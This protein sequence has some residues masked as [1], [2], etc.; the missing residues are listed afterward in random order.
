MNEILPEV[1]QWVNGAMNGLD[2][3]GKI[4]IG[5]L[6]VIVIVCV[7]WW[8]HKTS[9]LIHGFLKSA[10]QVLGCADQK[11]LRLLPLVNRSE[12]KGVYKGR[13]VEVGVVFSGFKSEFLPLPHIQVRLKET[14]GYNINRLPQYA[15]IEKNQLIYKLR[16]NLLWG[17]FDRN[18]IHVFSKNYLVIALEK[19]L[20]TAE[21]LERGREVKEFFK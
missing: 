14:L 2:G 17:V 4:L 9:V 7:F 16:L 3:F 5:T 8:L 19:L 15:F 21:D 18:Y 6:F 11:R 13:D 1:D 20:A 10:A 12:M